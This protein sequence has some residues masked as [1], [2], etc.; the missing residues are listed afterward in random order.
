MTP[1]QASSLVEGT[2]VIVPRPVF[3]PQEMGMKLQ[4]IGVV[5]DYALVGVR[6]ERNPIVD[7]R[8]GTHFSKSNRPI[9]DAHGY[10]WAEWS[11]GV[12]QQPQRLLT[13]ISEAEVAE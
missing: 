7:T 13:H 9:V 4:R 3:A 5:V 12:N 8:G 1:E 2:S 11:D 10:F 6:Y